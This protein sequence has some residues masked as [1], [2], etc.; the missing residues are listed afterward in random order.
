M[1][2]LLHPYRDFDLHSLCPMSA[3]SEMG[4][5][6]DARRV[7]RAIK[8]AL[9]LIAEQDPELARLLS[10]TIKTGEYLSYSPT[11]QPI[12]RHNPGAHQKRPITKEGTQAS[13]AED[14]SSHPFPFRSFTVVTS[15]FPLGR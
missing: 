8:L 11:S 13:D 12:P 2:G 3:D 10:R 4:K 5:D 7:T 6:R 14:E 1:L 9:M 15:N